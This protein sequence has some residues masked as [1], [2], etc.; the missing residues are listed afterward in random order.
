MSWTASSEM[1]GRVEVHVCAFNFTIEL[2]ELNSF[3]RQVQD[4]RQNLKSGQS[5]DLTCQMDNLSCV[6]LWKWLSKAYLKIKRSTYEGSLTS[7]GWFS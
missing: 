2:T 6:V 1:F 7:D 5:V 3:V 4:P